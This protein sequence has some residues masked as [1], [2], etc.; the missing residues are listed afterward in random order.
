MDDKIRNEFWDFHSKVRSI[1]PF[2]G[3]AKT[4]IELLFLR[5]LIDDVDDFKF[6]DVEDVK[7][8]FKL[9]TE[10]A[11]SSLTEE[12]LNAVFGVI[13]KVFFDGLS[14]IRKA[15]AVY[16]FFFS[17]SFKEME[18]LVK[19][20]MS[21]D[22]PK[23]PQSRWEVIKEAFNLST[24]DVRQFGEAITPEMLVSVGNALLD[25][26]QKDRYFDPF[27]GFSSAFLSLP[28]DGCG[29]YEG[30]EI[31]YEVCAVSLMLLV[32]LKKPNANVY[33]GDFFNFP[34]DHDIDKVFCDGPLSMRLTNLETIEKYETREADVATLYKIEQLLAPKG[35]AVM[36]VPGKFLYSAAKPYE[37]VRKHFTE[38]GLKAI[39]FFPGGVLPRTMVP[40]NLLLIE[41]GYSGPISFVD[42]RQLVKVSERDIKTIDQETIKAI[43]KSIDLLD[44]PT[45]WFKMVERATVAESEWCSWNP[46]LF[47]KGGSQKENR[48]LAEIEADIE[49]VAKQLIDLIEDEE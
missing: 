41:D 27:A 16:R 18:A 9:Q 36:T 28:E 2:Y 30:C 20:L 49:D 40:V 11:S 33:P 22:M 46:P 14:S 42:A 24:H 45:E 4:I 32:M 10:L 37:T 25:V 17:A 34:E 48:S 19:A 3:L 31:N 1:V 13:D 12:T 15:S 39:V 7:P 35:R 29:S 47:F 6:S 8:L 26:K 21:F 23:D 44:G 38:K 5:C 43:A